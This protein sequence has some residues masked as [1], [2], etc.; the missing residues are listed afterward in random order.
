MGGGIVE[1]FKKQIEQRAS[2]PFFGP[3]LFSWVVVNFQFV[4][5]VFKAEDFSEFSRRLNS[6]IYASSS[7]AVLM[8]LIVP[9]IGALF[10]VSVVPVLDFAFT[11]ISGWWSRVIEREKLRQKDLTPIPESEAVSLNE[12]IRSVQEEADKRVNSLNALYLSLVR[13]HIDVHKKHLTR[14]SEIFLR[15]PDIIFRIYGTDSLIRIGQVRQF[16]HEHADFSQ[17]A[18]KNGLPRKWLETLYEQGESKFYTSDCVRTL[19][20]L[21]RAAIDLGLMVSFGLLAEEMGSNLALS[22]YAT[23]VGREIAVAY[24]AAKE[25]KKLDL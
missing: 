3:F 4:Y 11:R 8:T 13:G 23:D 14:Y 12:K 16:D 7:S 15:V 22:F 1:T 18:S 20:D 2:H 19:G 25:A 17:F 21:D 9:T 6:E 10:Y 5:L 24:G